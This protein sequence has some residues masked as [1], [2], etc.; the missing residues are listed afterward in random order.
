M[1]PSL[2]FI[3][4]V[5]KCFC[6][7][8]LPIGSLI[9]GIVEI[10]LIGLCCGY[11]IFGT[12]DGETALGEWSYY[13]TI[14]FYVIFIIS[15]IF[16]IIT[17]IIPKQKNVLSSAVL[18]QLTL[19]FFLLA[20]SIIEFVVGII[21]DTNQKAVISFVEEVLLLRHDED[22]DDENGRYDEK[23]IE[24]DPCVIGP[25]AQTVGMVSTP[26]VPAAVAVIVVA[27]EEPRQK[28]FGDADDEGT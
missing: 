1:V 7:L 9:I 10:I 15:D 21:H 23:Q 14:I 5:D 27:D 13:L 6:L 4:T 24:Q 11:M 19:I 17:S 2:D 18:I 28:K 12:D 25:F 20:N 3:P 26:S 16:I 22:D 8:E